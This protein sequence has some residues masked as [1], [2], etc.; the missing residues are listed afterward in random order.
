MNRGLVSLVGAGHA[1]RSGDGEGACIA[2]SEAFAQE[3]AGR[4]RK[5]A[6]SPNDRKRALKG[7]PAI[8]IGWHAG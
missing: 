5:L 8:G 2:L 4:A 7:C 3:R 1:D 6:G